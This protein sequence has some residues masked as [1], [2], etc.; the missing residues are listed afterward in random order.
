M[1]DNLMSGVYS[2]LEINVGIICLSMPAFRRVLARL[3]PKCFGSTQ[4]DSQPRFNDEEVPNVR[5]PM[6]PTRRK[7]GTM[8]TSLFDTMIT[9][10]VDLSMESTARN[11][12]EVHLVELPKSGAKPTAPSLEG[13]TADD[14][15]S[16]ELRGFHYS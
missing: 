1:Y 5:Y 14:K 10:T 3:V 4:D 8:N 15:G 16:R 12:D 2:I 7:K 11:D 13:S 6:K 9:K